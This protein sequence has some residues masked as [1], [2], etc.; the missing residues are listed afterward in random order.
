M[1][2]KHFSAFLS[3]GLASCYPAEGPDPAHLPSCFASRVPQVRAGKAL[4]RLR[5]VHQTDSA[6]RARSV[7]MSIDGRQVYAGSDEPQLERELVVLTDVEV[8][9]GTHRLDSRVQVSG[10]G[11]GL[12]AHLNDY[13]SELAQER[14]FLVPAGGVSCLS[15]FVS[16]QG[17]LT[18]PVQER[19][20][21]VLL[22][23][24]APPR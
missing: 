1:K 22:E 17:G 16:Y 13:R 20:R 2:S 14:S 6:F 4:A 12:F 5:W 18:T 7:M 21:S 23:E 19:P 9:P 24:R 3:L 8:E 15:V 10:R 11:S